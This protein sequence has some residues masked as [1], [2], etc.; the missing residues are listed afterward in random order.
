M[1]GKEFTLQDKTDSENIQTDISD[2]V[3]DTKVSELGTIVY[4]TIGIASVFIQLG[5]SY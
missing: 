2:R 1:K 5:L 3:I 4:A